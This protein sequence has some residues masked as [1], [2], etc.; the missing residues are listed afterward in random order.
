MLTGWRIVP[1]DQAANAFDGEGAR[2]YGGRW[3]SAGVALVYASEHKSLAALETRVHIDA[4]KRLRRYKCFSF[5]FDDA[6][7]E[8]FAVRRLPRDWKEEPPPPSIQQLGD[9]WVKAAPSAVLAVPSII[10]PDERNYLLNPRHPDF[11]KIKIDKPTE[12]V[13]DQRLLK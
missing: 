10:I 4:T 12:F 11:A 6:L 7:M 1:E 5:H 8:I 13:F 3:N 9:L 2:L